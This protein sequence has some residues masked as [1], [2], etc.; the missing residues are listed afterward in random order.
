MF[1][2]MS[3]VSKT[4]NQEQ[5]VGEGE[6]SPIEDCATSCRSGGLEVSREGLSSDARFFLLDP[7][8][9][10]WGASRKATSDSRAVVLLPI[11]AGVGDARGGISK[12]RTK[13]QGR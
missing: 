1:R 6:E 10:K 8:S 7:L 11:A 3:A 9:V 12:E 5:I 2:T 4:S 13:Q